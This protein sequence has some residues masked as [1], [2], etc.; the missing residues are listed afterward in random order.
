MNET[1]QPALPFDR[2]TCVTDD[3]VQIPGLN[4]DCPVDGWEDVE[5]INMDN[6]CEMVKAQGVP[7]FVD[8]TGGGTA[9]LFAGPTIHRAEDP[10]WP[11]RA[12]CMGPGVFEEHTGWNFR[13][14]RAWRGECYIGPEDCDAPGF[15]YIDCEMM[16]E[17][18]MAQ[19]IVGLS[20]ATALQ[21]IRLF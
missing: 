21:Q 13:K 12:A 11:L 20:L 1:T 2:C 19:A 9:T 6:V 14:A 7:C 8:Q 5:P 4:P 17:E 16:S 18:A 3:G 15:D 10:D